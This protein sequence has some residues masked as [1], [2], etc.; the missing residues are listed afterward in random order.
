[1]KKFYFLSKTG[2]KLLILLYLKNTMKNRISQYEE[3]ATRFNDKDL[4][5]LCHFGWG[6]ALG[7]LAKSK[8]GKEAED[9]WTQAIEEYKKAV[10]INPDRHEAFDNW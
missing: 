7:N 10:E 4:N 9:L 5:S 3:K 1:M 2:K 6:Y 8:A